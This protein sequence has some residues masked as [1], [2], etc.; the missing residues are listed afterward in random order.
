MTRILVA[1]YKTCA[2]LSVVD[3]ETGAETRTIET[4]RGPTWITQAPSA[5][6][7]LVVCSTDILTL[8]NNLNITST[9]GTSG[10]RQVH[11]CWSREEDHVLI[12]DYDAGTV[13]VYPFVDHQL[14]PAACIHH[15]H[16]H[17]SYEPLQASSHPHQVIPGPDKRY[18]IADLGL[19]W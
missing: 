12:V 13:E 14:R 3:I 4:P 1:S 5:A 11:G 16:G 10:K 18:Y 17:G 9:I 6:H 19:D 15:F 2:S 7:I 8:D